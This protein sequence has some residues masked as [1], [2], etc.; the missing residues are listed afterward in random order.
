MKTRLIL[1]LPFLFLFATSCEDSD[2]AT[3]EVSKSTFEDNHR[4]NL[5]FFV[6]CGQ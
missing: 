4:H 2:S 1:L 3:L 6:D 5:Q